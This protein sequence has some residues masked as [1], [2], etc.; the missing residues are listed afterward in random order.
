L[1][2]RHWVRDVTTLTLQDIV[3]RE[4]STGFQYAMSIR[5]DGALRLYIH[6]DMDGHC[7][8]KCA[9][10]EGKRSRISLYEINLLIDADPSRQLLRG[11]AEHRR[12]INACYATP[13]NLGER[14]RRST[15]AA[16]DV[17]DSAT[18]SEFH[19]LGKLQGGTAATDV[20]LV[21]RGKI[22][23]LQVRQ[24]FSGSAQCGGDP[25]SEVS[26]P[27]VVDDGIHISDLSSIIDVLTWL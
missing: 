23:R 15:Q 22:G 17:E 6:S 4:D 1:G 5:I 12:E 20:K 9:C 24:I 21:D 2:P 16:S 27:I 11:L 18:S 26:D 10:I 19:S 8:V 13:V 25:S 14:A 3:H 7:R